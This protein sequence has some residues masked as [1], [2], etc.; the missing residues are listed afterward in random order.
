MKPVGL[1]NKC[2]LLATDG[3]KKK[4]DAFRGHPVSKVPYDFGLNQY[5]GKIGKNCYQAKETG[6][7]SNCC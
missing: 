7:N 2:R 3:I 5:T 1:L 4:K 6:N